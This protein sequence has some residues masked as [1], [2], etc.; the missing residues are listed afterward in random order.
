MTSPETDPTNPADDSPEAPLAGGALVRRRIG[1][2]LAV[3][4]V[5]T[6]VLMWVAAFNGWGS[7]DS[8][9]QLSDGRWVDQARTVCDAQLAEFDKL[10]A[11][12][13]ATT[14]QDRAATVEDSI[15]IFT[16]MTDEL[17]A[18]DPPKDPTE[19]SLVTDWL[20]DWDRHIEDRT[21]FAQE[22]ETGR[23]DSQFTE[24]LRDKK[25]IS[26]YIDRFARVN[27]IESCGTPGDL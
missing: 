19:A 12:S 21:R 9:D 1:M 24:S 8:I 18:L 16:T 22:L 14:P 23:E 10:P 26:R 11:A 13:D 15:V 6:I 17:A 25:Q 3:V 4:G 27:D 5:L 2:A 20:G 7:T